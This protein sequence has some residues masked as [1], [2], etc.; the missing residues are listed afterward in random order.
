MGMNWSDSG[1]GPG[2]MCNRESRPSLCRAG[3]AVRSIV[4]VVIGVEGLGRRAVSEVAS[5]HARAL[6]SD[7]D[8][9][10]MQVTPANVLDGGLLGLELRSLRGGLSPGSHDRAEVVRWVVRRPAWWSTPPDNPPARYD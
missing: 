4:S 10:G 8:H 6:A 2:D 9:L 5:T 1:G 3:G 7:L